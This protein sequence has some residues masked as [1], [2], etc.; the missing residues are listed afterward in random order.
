MLNLVKKIKS[1]LM[2][3]VE[4]LK[5]FYFLVRRFYTVEKYKK[6]LV[7]TIDFLGRVLRKKPVIMSGITQKEKKLLKKMY[8]SDAR[9]IRYRIKILKIYLEKTKNHKNEFSELA[10]F[11]QNFVSAYE[12]VSMLPQR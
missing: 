1:F 3:C 4:G 5:F 10:G 11:V 12:K 7:K 2:D 9:T 6:E 8:Q